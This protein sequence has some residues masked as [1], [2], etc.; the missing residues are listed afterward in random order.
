MGIQSSINSLLSKIE[1]VVRYQK[2]YQKVSEAVKGQEEQNEWFRNAAKVLTTPT[3]EDETKPWSSRPSTLENYIL[4]QKTKMIQ[5]MA[6]AQVKDR[7]DT[8][9]Q[10]KKGFDEHTASLIRYYGKGSGNP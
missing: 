7:E 9:N 5:N 3:S 1:S 2:G 8:I 6:K 10:S 4:G